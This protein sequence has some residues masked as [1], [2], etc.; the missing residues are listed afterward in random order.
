MANN[1]CILI[2]DDSNTNVVLLQAVLQ[3]RGYRTTTAGSVKEAYVNMNKEK[4]D[5]IL[6]DL[7]MPDVSGFDF[8]SQVRSNDKFGNIPVVVVSALT[9]EENINKTLELGAIEFIKK[10]IDIQCMVRIVENTLSGKES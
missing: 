5:L 2:I 6:L 7:L 1:H 3:T 8:L 9:D 4:P 10:P